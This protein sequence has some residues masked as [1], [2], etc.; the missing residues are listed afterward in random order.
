VAVGRGL[1][2]RPIACAEH[3]HRPAADRCDDC[4]QPSCGECLVR[5]GETLRCRACTEAVP[6]REAAALEA[7]R[8][9]NRLRRT[10]RERL[11]G[12]V[13]AAVLAGVLGGAFALAL[14]GSRS[15]AASGGDALSRA[16]ADEP[17]VRQRLLA[18]RYCA[19]GEG[20]T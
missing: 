8:L 11:G 1:A 5:A 3:P 6:A 7:R 13:A 19:G 14:W 12:L 10:L 15:G 20:T 16:L 17:A 9:G 18:A 2:E 4:R